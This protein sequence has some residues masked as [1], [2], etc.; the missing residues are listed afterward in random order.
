MGECGRLGGRW[1]VGQTDRQAVRQ[2][3]SE[4]ERE[5]ERQTE[6][7]TV[8]QT[9]R[10]TDRDHKW[11]REEQEYFQWKVCSAVCVYPSLC[12]LLCVCV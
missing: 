6:R 1:M 4:R 3:D 7:Q 10:Q 9:D 12:V 2:T 8:R 11:L 5:R